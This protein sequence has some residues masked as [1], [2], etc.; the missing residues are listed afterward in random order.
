M[1][2]SHSSLRQIAGR[3]RNALD[4]PLRRPLITTR[5]L[6]GLVAVV[7]VGIWAAIY[8][9]QTMEQLQTYPLL[10]VNRAGLAEESKDAQRQSLARAKA[11]EADLAQW[12]REA[13]SANALTERYLTARLE[14][15]IVNAKY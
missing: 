2:L 3:L 6:M 1:R 14:A 9:P 8:L 12:R 7:A 11:F 10:A 13:E 5:L 15:E 4:V